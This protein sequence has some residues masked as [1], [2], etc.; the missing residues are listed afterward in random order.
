MH[1]FPRIV[2]DPQ[3]SEPLAF[4]LFVVIEN[5][6]TSSDLT[7][8][9]TLRVGGLPNRRHD[10]I[11]VELSHRIERPPAAS[12]FRGCAKVDICRF[13]LAVNIRTCYST[14]LS[15]HCQRR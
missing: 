2:P 7:Y 14:M 5:R 11:P 3:R 12:L 9:K 1:A 10:A 8:R 4:R 15:P 6:L 13:A